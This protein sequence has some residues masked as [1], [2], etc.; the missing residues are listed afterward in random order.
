MRQ[1]DWVGAQSFAPLKIFDLL[2]RFFELVLAQKRNAPFD[3]RE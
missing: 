2:Q 1:V 3:T